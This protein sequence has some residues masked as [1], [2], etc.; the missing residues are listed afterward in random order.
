MSERGKL[1][2]RIREIKAN[3]GAS[4]QDLTVLSPQRDPYRLDTPAGHR[5][6]KWFA[7]YFIPILGRRASLHLRGVHYGLVSTEGLLK[8][9]GKPY[10]NTDGD[11]E[12]LQD[13]PAKAAR[14]LGYIPFDRIHDEKNAEPVVYI[15]EQKFHHSCVLPGSPSL[16]LPDPQDFE[17]Y[18]SV[19]NLEGRQPYHLVMFGEKSSLGDILLPLAARYAADCFLPS[20]ELS[21]TQIYQMAANGAADGR[22]MVVFI[23]ADCDPA[24]YQM[25]ISIAR[26]L[27]GLKDLRFHDL[28]FEVHRVALTVDQVRELNLPSTPLKDGERRADRWRETFGVEQTEIDALATLQ[29]DVL[30]RIVNAAIKPFFDATMVRRA[31]EAEAEWRDEA[32]RM[33]DER[34]EPGEREEREREIEKWLAT[35][36]EAFDEF[37]AEKAAELPWNFGPPRPEVV[38]PIIDA[39]LHPE[40]LASSSWS[41]EELTAALKRHKSYGE[42]ERSR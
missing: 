40:P 34:L 20:G 21:D 28:D 16:N 31:R 42:Q 19:G 25:G 27:Q 3:S 29:P 12:W 10:R 36:Q 30:R 22:P 24:G 15:H 14:W 37:K 1:G 11:W 35:Q 33:L 38:E 41:W 17:P 32:Q 13:G 7:T 23:L 6:A 39:S 5:D 18:V 2:A 9:N 4:L 26:K 8:P